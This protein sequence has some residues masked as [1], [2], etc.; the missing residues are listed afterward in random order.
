M[1]RKDQLSC[2]DGILNNSLNEI[3]LESSRYYKEKNRGFLTSLLISNLSLQISL[4]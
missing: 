1:V 3:I 4:Q 2:S